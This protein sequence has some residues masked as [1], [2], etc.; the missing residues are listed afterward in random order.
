MGSFG[1]KVNGLFVTKMKEFSVGC[2][3]DMLYM[4]IWGVF[5]TKKGS[6]GER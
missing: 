1:D 5:N 3:G 6:L 4:K 2:F